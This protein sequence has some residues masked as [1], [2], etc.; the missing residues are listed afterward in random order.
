MEIGGGA[1]V[2]MCNA[3]CGQLAI[4]VEMTTIRWRDSN[5][6]GDDEG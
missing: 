2:V 3:M 6:M 4:A 5:A 1:V